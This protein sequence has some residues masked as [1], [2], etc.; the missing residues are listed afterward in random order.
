MNI[1]S[2]PY[3]DS[4]TSIKKPSSFCARVPSPTPPLERLYPQ[5]EDSTG[6][7]AEYDLIEHIE[8][9]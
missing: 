3:R 5:G 1:V 4:D 2:V 7:E 6:N 9:S 8:C